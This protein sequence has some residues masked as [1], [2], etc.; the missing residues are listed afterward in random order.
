MFKL[1]K[2]LCVT[3]LL[4][5]F[6][7]FAFGS[8][9]FYGF[10]AGLCNLSEAYPGDNYS[11]GID[12]ISFNFSVTCFP[13]EGMWGFL[14][15][16]TANRFLSGRESDGSSKLKRINTYPLFDMRFYGAPSIKLQFGEKLRVPISLG[17]VFSLFREEIYGDYYYEAEYV[18]PY[19]DN[20]LFYEA[21]GM[22]VFVDASL[23]FNP[24][25]KEW[26]FFKNGITLEYN[27]LR[28]ERGENMRMQSGYFVNTPYAAFYGTL[29][30]GVGIFVK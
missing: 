18:G 26:F 22:G 13:G 12:G 1:K 25:K 5:G 30:F 15:Q 8:E 29:Y 16:T 9:L 19:P 11:R 21:I 7:A 10:T 14:F 27:F 23:I 28:L 17:P 24:F 4:L 6:S 3:L 20:E 2:I